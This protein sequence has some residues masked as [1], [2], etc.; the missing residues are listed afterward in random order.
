MGSKSNNVIKAII[1]ISILFDIIIIIFEIGYLTSDYIIIPK[2]T[3][4]R[5]FLVNPY[6]NI[7]FAVINCLSAFYYFKN[8]KQFNM[9][10]FSGLI[11]IL[12]ILI[13]FFIKI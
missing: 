13:P 12:L 6:L 2:I 7:S 9:Y 4:I 5:S 1:I 8:K 3:S 10:I 11:L